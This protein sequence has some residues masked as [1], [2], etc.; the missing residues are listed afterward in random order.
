MDTDADTDTET[1]SSYRFRGEHY[2]ASFKAQQYFSTLAYARELPDILR[3]ALLA[4]GATI[5][6]EPQ[7]HVFDNGAAT[8]CFLLSE[9]HCAVH[10]YPEHNAL[11]VDCFTCGDRFRTRDFHAALVDKLRPRECTFQIFVRE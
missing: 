5:L 4:C 9:S 10:T 8:L 2:V 6:G 7:E 1:T 11:F 3:S